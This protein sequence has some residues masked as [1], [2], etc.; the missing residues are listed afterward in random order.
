MNIPVWYSFNIKVANNF[1]HKSWYKNGVKIVH[2]FLGE[3]YS[4]LGFDVFKDIYNL[5]LFSCLILNKVPTL[6]GFLGHLKVKFNVEGSK[7]QSG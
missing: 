4:L 6:I 1:F 7:F 2:D 5:Y 3:D